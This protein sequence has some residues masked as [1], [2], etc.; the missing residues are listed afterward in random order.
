MNEPF[1]KA[2]QRHGATVLRV[3][4]A[5]LGAGPDADDA[6]S[7]TFLAALRS[8]PDLDEATNVD[9]WLVRVAKRKAVDIARKRARHAVP[10]GELPEQPSRAGIPG[11]GDHELWQ[12]VAALP[13]RQ[14]LALAY[15]YLGGL[16][17]AETAELIGGS[18]AAV[19][20]AAADGIKALRQ[21]PSFDEPRR[22]ADR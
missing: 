16:A 13:E 10:T 14:R 7:E 5:V 6:W 11:A 4:R 1:E 19:R 20:R 22:G 18:A 8:W 2:V 12:A 3:C 9:A 17:H 21:Q 15:H